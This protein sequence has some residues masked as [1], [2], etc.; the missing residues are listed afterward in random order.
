MSSQ[1][2]KPPFSPPA[3]YRPLPTPKVLQKKNGPTPNSQTAQAKLKPVAPPVYRPEAKKIVQPKVP[4]HA[5]QRAP[6]KSTGP[7]IQRMESSLLHK[8]G[9]L[10]APVVT[11]IFQ[12]PNYFEMPRF[13]SCVCLVFNRTGMSL[14]QLKAINGD[15]RATFKQIKEKW[16][17]GGQ[18]RPFHAM[19]PYSDGGNISLQFSQFC[20]ECSMDESKLGSNPLIAVVGHCRPGSPH[21]S[22]DKGTGLQ[23]S[24][25]NVLDV[26]RPLIKRGGTILLTP[27]NT[28]ISEQ[29]APS[30]Q[31]RLM[32]EI[33]WNSN[34]TVDIVGM[35]S[36]SFPVGGTI[37]T[38][39]MTVK[40][41][42]PPPRRLPPHLDP[43]N[44]N[45]FDPHEEL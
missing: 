14:K 39:G 41:A 18:D 33:E 15:Y 43:R 30:F 21:I 31:D 1:T 37:V 12:I 22:G 32:G 23:F 17:M 19:C 42:N 16:R 29:G 20:A 2:K 36:T 7:V 45:K 9:T 6:V 4:A 24:V 3:V 27:C 26:I 44:V 40:T 25:T 38:T 13:T 8:V 11:T 5:V 35:R 34:T 28:A 10:I